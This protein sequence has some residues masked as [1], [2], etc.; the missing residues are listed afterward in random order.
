MRLNNFDLNLLVALNA[1]LDERSVTNAARRLNMTQPAMSA[2]L[3]RLRLSFDDKLLVAYGK[4]MALTPYAEDLR[5]RVSRALAD[6]Q[7]LVSSS[8][9]FDPATSKR[10]FRLAASDYIA[11][12]LV[13]PVLSQLAREA[14][15]VVI[16]ITPPHA[17]ISAELE[18]GEVDFILT[19]EEF[20]TPTH[21]RKLVFEERHVVLG[22]CEN[23][24]FRTAL[25]EEAF[26]AAG[27][28]VVKLG[29]NASTYAERYMSA[30]GDRRRIEVVASSFTIVPWMLPHTNRIAL[31]HER[32]AD[33]MLAK[34]PL[35]RADPPFTMPAMREMIQYHTARAMD[36]GVQWFLRRL[37]DVA[38]GLPPSA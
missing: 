36:G 3:R 14:P 26:D 25:T 37:L 9:L 10:M 15:G 4:K 16:T 12:V 28:V 34:L 30:R 5:L 19:P 21:P 1:L 13:I 7:S 31:V 29:V 24:I 23:P 6:L 18:R 2:A 38:G 33:I 27:H 8:P 22:W 32:L 20:T 11:T 17:G 35:V